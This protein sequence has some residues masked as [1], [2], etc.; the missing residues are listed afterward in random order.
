MLRLTQPRARHRSRLY[1]KETH[2]LIL[3]AL[4][5]T[6]EGFNS[7]LDEAEERGLVNSKTR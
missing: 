4:K 5:I 7:R 1:V 6:L 2:L 3:T